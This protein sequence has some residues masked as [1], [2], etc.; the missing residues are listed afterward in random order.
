MPGQSAHGAAKRTLRTIALFLLAPLIAA[1]LLGLV[2]A[3][4]IAEFQSAA[5]YR[6]RLNQA[7]E[8]RNSIWNVYSLLK[9]AETG[10]RGF[11]LTRDPK[12]LAP[13]VTASRL[14]PEKIHS[15]QGAAEGQRSNVLRFQ[16]LSR[17]KLAELALTVE[18]LQQGEPSRAM[19]I[20][21]EGGGERLMDEI[22][23]LV[24]TMLAEEG[25]VIQQQSAAVQQQADRY[26]TITLALLAGILM[27]VFAVSALSVGY[28]MRRREAERELRA[29]REIADL[30]RVQAE[31]ANRAKTDFLASMSHEIRTPLNGI[32]GFTELLLDEQL[33]PEQRRYL[34]RIHFAGAA[35]LT[36]VNDVLDF[37]KIEA[38]RIDLEFHPFSFEALI[39]NTV[40]IVRRAARQKGLKMRVILDPDIPDAMMGDEARL[41]QILLNLLNNAVK[42][43]REGSVTLDV[44]RHAATSRDIIR[45]A[46]SDTGIGIA[47]DQRE[48]LF[49]RFSQ[50]NYSIT[51]EFG[52]TGLGLAISKRLVDAMDGEIGFESEEG[53]GATFWFKV[54]L[55]QTGDQDALHQIALRSPKA[56]RLGRILLVEDLEHNRD[57]AEKILQGAGHEV[58]IAK[59]GAEAVEAVQKKEYDLV[60]M[61]IQ[62]PVMDGVTATRKIRELNLPVRRIPIIAMSANVLPQQVKSFMEAGMNDHVGKPIKRAELF[63]KLN[64]WL[65]RTDVGSNATSSSSTHAES[66]AFRELCG[67]MGQNW[68]TG[69]LTTLRLKI[70][71][72]FGDETTAMADPGQLAL[73]A[74]AL[75]SHAALLGFVRLSQLCSQLEEACKERR[76]LPEAFHEAKAAATIAAGRASDM[77]GMASEAVR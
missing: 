37:S 33:R 54:P 71:E 19:A 42:F 40:S 34:E 38:G 35:L 21:K 18:A 30:A 13:Y 20:V 3:G 60:L 5:A 29:A 61:D 62:M 63:H 69:G 75:V 23:G 73:R 46:V 4:V 15:L 47:P 65:E 58:E 11:L 44:G 16:E 24:N 57:L 52:G 6:G 68:A 9:D 10:Q 67:L 2:L 12:Y 76:N 8:L 51:R 1:T 48:H 70:D 56:I 50:A 28:A 59:N 64:T 26:Q 74:H 77:L 55:L 49:K 22:R 43:T 41:R 45:F 72:A 66:M 39:D 36:I 14:L 32:I 25:L 53:K 27:L 17:Q 7:L 31:E